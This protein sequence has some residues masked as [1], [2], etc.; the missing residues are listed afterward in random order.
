MAIKSYAEYLAEVKKAY[1]ARESEALAAND[2]KYSLQKQLATDTYNRQKNETEKSYT[3]LYRENE[4][5]KLINEREV[6]ENMANSGLTDS[7]LNRTQ[8]TAVQLSYANQKGKIDTTKQQAIDTLA[9]S[10]ADSVAQLD[11]ARSESAANIKD[12]YAALAAE[13]AE[14]LYKSALQEETERIKATLEAQEKE[15]EVLQKA[16]E[17]EREANHIIKTNKGALSYDYSGSLK[18]NGVSVYYTTDSKGNA[19]TRYV[20]NNSGKITEISSDT[21]PYT[22]TV[23]ADTANGVFSNGY[24]PDNINGDKLKSTGNKIVV[25]GRSQTVW[26]TTTKNGFFGEKTTKNYVWDG[27]TNSYSQVKKDENGDWKVVKTNIG[28]VTRAKV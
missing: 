12:S 10:L 11:I 23:N 26:S 7:G 19:I 9:A 21:N 1:S 14:S 3:D 5:Q 17:A 16:Q 22:F 20:D 28:T 24:Q 8:Q 4:V 2:E 25:N 15:Q 27:A 13:E 18:D 6:A